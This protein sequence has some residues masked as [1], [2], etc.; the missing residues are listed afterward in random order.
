[1]RYA[2]RVATFETRLG[3][4]PVRVVATSTAVEVL[5]LNPDGPPEYECDD[6]QPLVRDALGQLTAYFQGRLT[7]FDLPLEMAGTPF[8]KR[9]WDAL[10]E[11]PYGE[12]CSYGELARNIGRPSAVR[13]VGA[14]NGSNPIAII[15]PCHRVIGASGKLVG[16]GGGLPMKRM[17]L[18]LEAEHARRLR[19]AATR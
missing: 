19:K 6:N 3:K 1:M 10:R 18:D 17:L 7:E 8:Q 12:T 5:E 2:S 13:A 4:C 14:A 9:V 11:I 15:V 16:Y